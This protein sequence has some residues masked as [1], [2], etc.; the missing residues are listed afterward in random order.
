[1]SDE[2]RKILQLIHESKDPGRAAEIAIGIIIDEIKRADCR[3][4]LAMTGDADCHTVDE[5]LED[6]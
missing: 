5:I 1:M 2:E 6:K 3:A 4:S